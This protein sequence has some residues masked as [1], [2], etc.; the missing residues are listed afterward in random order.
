VADAERA[1]A[2]DAQTSG[3][4][5]AFR[6]FASQRAW[7]FAPQPVKTQRFLAGR[8][9]PA[10]AIR[11]WPV[12]TTTA[13]DGSLALS[14]GQAIAANGGRGAF[15]TIWTVEPGTGWRWLADFGSDP[16][17]PDTPVAV[18]ERRASCRNLAAAAA[19]EPIVASPLPRLDGGASRDAS[20]R[21]VLRGDDKAHL[22]LVWAWDGRGWREIARK[23]GP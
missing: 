11:W 23:V 13:C 22:L 15:N 7:M 14:Q 19:S 6:R 9:D 17:G 3:Q 5:T 10:K 1:F 21:W 2:A 20:L 8:A 12:V 18:T 16:S 4:W